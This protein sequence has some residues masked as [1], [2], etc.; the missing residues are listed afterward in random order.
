MDSAHLA[1][2]SADV[3][4]PASPTLDPGSP[5]RVQ[6]HRGGGV[7]R[8]AHHTWPASHVPDPQSQQ[9]TAA[10]VASTATHFFFFQ[11]IVVEHPAFRSLFPSVIN[12]SLCLF[13]SSVL[14]PLSLGSQ[15]PQRLMEPQRPTQYQLRKLIMI[16]DM[17]HPRS[18]LLLLIRSGHCLITK[19]HDPLGGLF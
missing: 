11:I 8:G 7:H 13:S 14:I 5:Q 19:A 1:G 4:P 15:L 9:G 12:N 3:F 6:L 2:V 16:Y 10:C 18:S 17:P